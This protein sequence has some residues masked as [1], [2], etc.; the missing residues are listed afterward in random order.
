MGMSANV[1]LVHFP[2][3]DEIDQS[4]AEKA[5]NK[6]YEKVSRISGKEAIKV[7]IQVRNYHRSLGRKEYEVHTRF[8][9]PEIKIFSTAK[10][11][12]FLSALEDSLKILES[13]TIKR[14]KR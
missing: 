6:S 13:E 12:N 9:D 1:E 3:L 8:A 14:F 4:L 10:D 2:S 11:W 5:I 7:K